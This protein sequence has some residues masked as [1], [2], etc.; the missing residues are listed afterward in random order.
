MKR[1]LKIIITVLSAL[2]VANM[3]A[4][5]K[6]SSFD[7]PPETVTAYQMIK[8]DV[9]LSIFRYAVERADLIS[10]L[11]GKNQITIFMPTNAAFLSSGY[12]QSVLSK[13]SI[14]DLAAFVKNH[15]VSGSI[16]TRNLAPSELRTTLSNKQIL[17]QRIGVSN[18]VDGADIT[19][20][21]KKMSNGY[22][23]LINK[24]IVTKPTMFDAINDYT[25]TTTLSQFNLTIAAITRASTGAT[26][27][28]DLLKGSKSYTFFLPT[29][30]AWID[31]GYANLAA[32]NSASVTVLETILKNHL[33]EGAKFTS[34]ID[35]GSITATSGLKIYIDKSIPSRTTNSY[36]NGIL[37]GNG[38]ASNIE[39]NNGVIHTVK[40]LIPTPIATNTLDR[41]K[42][43]ANLTLFAAMLKR[44]SE[45]NAALN[46]ESMLSDPLMTYTVF[47]VNNTGIMARYQNI[48]A[49]NNENPSVI[50]ELLK[51]HII[52]RRTNNINFAENASAATLS[53]TVNTTGKEI[54][55]S[56]IFL[57]NGGFKVKGRGNTGTVS[58]ITPNV[59]TTNGLLNIIGTILEP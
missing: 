33:V 18:Y 20:P 32:V 36:A 16:D 8:E 59:T 38:N 48:A 29:N 23:Q 42:S 11:D 50:A 55:N 27:F 34:Q 7:Y 56:I 13:M 49:I 22:V 28:I 41:I 17:I 2:I 4:C 31:A 15:I 19:N 58:V 53:K 52:F 30:N 54:P 3:T 46:F 24:V 9:T 37:F 47:A 26:N 51:F 39:A 21:N 12:T 35:S 44:G 45:A 25:T 5:K 57:I 10:L 43:D 6:L 1:N 40:R 14:N